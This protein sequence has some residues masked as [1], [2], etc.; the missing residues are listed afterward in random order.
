VSLVGGFRSADNGGPAANSTDSALTF[1][2]NL[3]VAQNVGLHW[4][5]NKFSGS[6]YAAGQGPMRPGGTGTM[7]NTLMLSAGF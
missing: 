6:A 2:V 4:I 1:G 7:L 3:M 5:F